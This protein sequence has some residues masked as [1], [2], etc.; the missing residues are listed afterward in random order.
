M[1]A[2]IVTGVSRGLGEALAAELLRRDFH[3]VGVG[4]VS[5]AKLGGE[6]YRFVGCD[7]AQPARIA[8]TLVPALRELA[9][10]EPAAVTL[11]NNAAVPGPVGL[12]G[13]LDAAEIEAAVATNIAAPLVVADLFL[14]AFPDDAVER[15][16]INLSSGAARSA[17]AG[18]G[19]YSMAKAAIEMLTLAL[20]ADH[21][22]PNF[23]AIA[24]RP[25]IF[26]TGMQQFMRSRDP[27]LFPSVELFRGFKAQGLLK[28]PADVAARIVA[29]LVLAPVEH[30]RTY[31]HTDL[32]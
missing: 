6:R 28:D 29:K 12:I 9:A 25:G 21:A 2:A 20:A 30:G 7:L 16:I 27:A 26:E 1:K 19:A 5:S 13:R 10:G 32:D 17:L 23:R 14:R 15:R 11:I 8:A 3:V 4:R 24:V 22:A 31:V 18:S